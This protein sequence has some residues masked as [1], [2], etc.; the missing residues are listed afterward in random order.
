MSWNTESRGYI[1]TWA[2]DIRNSYKVRLKYVLVPKGVEVESHFIDTPYRFASY[3]EAREYA[4]E[5]FPCYAYT[6][7][8]SADTPNFNE[9]EFMSRGTTK[10]TENIKYSQ[11]FS[12]KEPFLYTKEKTIEE[13]ESEEEIKQKLVDIEILRAKLDKKEGE[14][15]KKLEANSKKS[16]K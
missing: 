10:E 7:E 12:I 15:K 11:V 9:R 13:I 6:V 4:K 14:L 3:K 8:G 16:K 5:L 2:Q 1:K